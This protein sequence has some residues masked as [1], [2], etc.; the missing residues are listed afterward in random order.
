MIKFATFSVAERTRIAF[1][2][3]CRAKAFVLP[4]IDH[5][6]ES[7]SRPALIVQTFGLN[8]LLDQPDHIVG[9]ENGEIRSEVH[10]FRMT[11]QKLH[12]DRVERAEPWHSFNGATD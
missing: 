6:G 9:I 4:S 3:I 8:K 2:N 12:T 10:Q 5:V 11:A 1:R 7:A